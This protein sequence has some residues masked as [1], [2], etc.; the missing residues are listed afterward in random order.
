[1]LAGSERPSAGE[2]MVEGQSVSFRHPA[3]AIRAGVVYV[4]ADCAEALLMQR[5]VRENITLPTSARIC[6]W[7]RSTWN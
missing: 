1:M 2:V 6:R 7:G 3:D 4:A 5:N